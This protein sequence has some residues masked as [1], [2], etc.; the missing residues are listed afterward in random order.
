[1]LTEA[2]ITYFLFL[3]ETLSFSETAACF[4]VSQQAISKSIAGLEEDLQ[5]TLFSRSRNHVQLTHAGEAWRDTFARLSEE[6]HQAKNA[7]TG[8]CTPQRPALRLGCQNYMSLEDL[9]ADLLTSQEH[10]HPNADLQLMW[11]SPLD[12]LE[13]LT[14]HQ[15]DLIL[16]CQ[17]FVSNTAGLRSFPLLQVP[18]VLRISAYHPKATDAATYTDLICEPL[19]IDMMAWENQESCLKRAKQ[20]CERYGLTPSR[21]IVTPNRDSAY[22][23]VSMG[24]GVL[25]GT[26][27][28]RH[29]SA[30]H[31]KSYSCRVS[32]TLICMWRDNEHNP[33]V[34][35]SLDF[36]KKLLIHD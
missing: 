28:S 4:G 7:I 11:Y 13:H 25:L 23:M 3:T 24:Q 29:S 17:R 5:T 33:L 35:E 22:T 14:R 6:Y 1:M 26:S 9:A 15:L 8:L 12:L 18:L 27:N 31:L 36:F 20:E 16:I 19:V 32:D 10:L 21:I 34:Q 2:K 30:Y